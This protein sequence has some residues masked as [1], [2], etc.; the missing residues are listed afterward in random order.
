MR[1]NFIL[2][3]AAIVHLAAPVNE[4]WTLEPSEVV[5][6]AVSS[7]T[8]VLDSALK[9]GAQLRSV[10]FMSSAAALFD[11][12]PVPGVYS[13]KDWN[14]TSEPAVKELGPDAGGLHAYCASKTVAERAFW[15]FRD[16]RKPAFSMTSIQATYAL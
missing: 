13:E 14:T 10:V 3:C 16:E 8:G 5:R 9:A 7:T 12:P 6:M 1:F 4:T 15:R 2:G 11:V